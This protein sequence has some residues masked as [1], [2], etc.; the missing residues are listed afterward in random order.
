MGVLVTC[1]AKI[2]EIN[3]ENN[4]L[5]NTCQLFYDCK[6]CGA[7]LRPKPGDCCVYC[8]YAT[9]PCPPVQAGEGCC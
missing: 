1:L 5:M 3:N 2:N 7:V 8:S 4:K 9:V 6:G